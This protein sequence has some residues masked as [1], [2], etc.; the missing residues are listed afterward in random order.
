MKWS[1]KINLQFLR[2][3]NRELKF[4]KNDLSGIILKKYSPFRERF[5]INYLWIR[6]TGIYDKWNVMKGNKMHNVSQ[7]QSYRNE[8]LAPNFRIFL[9]TQIFSFCIL[10]AEYFT[11]TYNKYKWNKMTLKNVISYRQFLN[12]CEINLLDDIHNQKIVS[13]NIYFLFF[14]RN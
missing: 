11:Y 5:L 8:Y 14:M 1:N 12:D 13:I 9:T 3:A 6:E 4:Q 2:S 10:I 7:Y